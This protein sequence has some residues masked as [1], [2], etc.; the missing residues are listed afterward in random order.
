MLCK[1]LKYIKFS[2]FHSLSLFFFFF[3]PS[4]MVIFICYLISYYLHQG[5]ISRIS[6]DMQRHPGPAPWFC[7]QHFCDPAASGFSSYLHHWPDLCAM[8]QQGGEGNSSF[9]L[10]W[11]PACG[12]PVLHK[13]PNY[14]HL[15]RRGMTVSSLPSDHQN[16]Q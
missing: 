4:F 2:F 9:S 13:G 16:E 14:W 6:E 10:A 3:F 11:H 8:P 7:M 15:G 12:R 5:D 1:E